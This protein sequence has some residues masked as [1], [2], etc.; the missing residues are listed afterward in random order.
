MPLAL[1]EL[2]LFW[3]RR[4]LAG[5]CDSET[6]GG[7]LRTTLLKVGT[8]DANDDASYGTGTNNV[9]GGVGI[10]FWV[11]TWVMLSEFI[12]AFSAITN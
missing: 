3:L 8:N 12:P 2:H 9:A 4:S 11:W 10:L 7:F 6:E 5:A 1:R